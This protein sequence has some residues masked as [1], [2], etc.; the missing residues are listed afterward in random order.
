MALIKRVRG[1][2]KRRG[3]F[4]AG[5]PTDAYFFDDGIVLVYPSQAI[6]AIPAFGAL[7]AAIGAVLV[8]RQV[9]RMQSAASDL[10]ASEFAAARKHAELLRYSDLKSVRLE[11]K[12]AK[13]RRII[14]ENTGEPHRLT[15]GI[16]AWSDDEAKSTLGS[17]LGD[18]FVDAL[19]TA[20]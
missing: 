19:Q 18:R 12:S 16:K 5:T 10:S 3:V 2:T 15:Y 4:W 14:V 8:E 20:D 17:R 13:Q 6:A 11:L 7:G 1:L 9:K